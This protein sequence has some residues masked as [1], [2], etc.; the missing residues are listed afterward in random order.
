MRHH[1]HSLLL[2]ILLA[3][4]SFIP[5]PLLLMVCSVDITLRTL[6]LWWKGRGFNS[7]L[8]CYQLL[9]TCCPVSTS[10][11]DCLWAGKPFHYVTSR[12]GQ[13]RLSF[14][15]LYVNRVPAC[16]AGL[17]VG[18]V[19]RCRVAASMSDLILQV[20]LRSS[21]NGSFNLSW[22][23]YYA[24]FLQAEWNNFILQCLSNI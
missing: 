7:G 21:A 24:A 20:T 4:L 6:D 19:Y 12:P 3:T 17:E 13:L 22:R 16:L 10:I 15:F 9:T 1:R 5:R 11:C 2:L 18:R 8:G 23:L 14:L